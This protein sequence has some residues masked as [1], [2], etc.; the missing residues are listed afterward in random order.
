[1]NDSNS[2]PPLVTI[3]TASPVDVHTNLFRHDS[4]HDQALKFLLDNG[5]T[6]AESDILPLI[7]FGTLSGVFRLVT[8]GIINPHQ[9]VDPHY[10]RSV[11][12]IISNG[13]SR[14]TQSQV[15]EMPLVSQRL[16]N[17]AI[18]ATHCSLLESDWVQTLSL[19]VIDQMKKILSIEHLVV[20]DNMYKNLKVP[21][22]LQQLSRNQVLMNVKDLPRISIPQ[23]RLP[24]QIQ[25][26]LLYED[27]DVDVMIK[28]Y[29]DTIDHINDNGVSNVVYV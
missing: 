6:L 25:G 26:Y 9:L 1:M 14:Q 4:L 24:K 3:L 21:K 29:K 10:L 19:L 2:L 16:L 5:A 13:F 17:I 20:I 18:I 7:L 22:S 8:S 15:F 23:M 28:E 11:R 12:A 27:I